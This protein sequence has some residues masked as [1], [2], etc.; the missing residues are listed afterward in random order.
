MSGFFSKLFGKKKEISGVD[1]LVE[2]NL[3]ELIKLS[4]LDIHFEI[5]KKSGEDGETI[6]IDLS[7][8]DEELL[9]ERDG[10]LLESIQLFLKRVA[11][12]NYPEDRTHIVVDSSKFR[13]ESNQELQDLAEKL[14]EAALD[15]NRPVYCRALP[16]KDRKIVHQY[17]A[18]DSRVKSRSVGDGL[19]KKIKIYPQKL[20]DSAD[21]SENDRS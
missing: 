20:N 3:Q 17:L 7:G 1:A 8:P 6:S 15:K 10:A 5:D 18:T 9:K 2:D 14:K 16:P 12:H 11:Q 21:S 19:Y 4:L 13:D